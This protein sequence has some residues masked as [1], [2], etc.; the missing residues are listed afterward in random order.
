MSTP[1]KIL[2]KVLEKMAQL[3]NPLKLLKNKKT[4]LPKKYY[5]VLKR[6]SFLLTITMMLMPRPAYSLVG[7]GSM[8]PFLNSYTKDLTGDTESIFSLWPYISIHEY[9]NLTG[10]FFFIPEVGITL[11]NDSYSESEAF[12]GNGDHASSR[13]M[14]FILA[15]FSYMFSSGSHLRFGAGSFM[16]SISGEGGAVTRNDGA[17]TS[18]HYLPSEKVT[19]YNTTI[20]LGLEQFIRP[21]M[22]L[23]FES[24]LWNILSSDSRRVNFS[25][26]F[27]Y[28][29]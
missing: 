6:I 22:A 29:L 14:T 1:M 19:S 7:V 13:Q 5:P 26:A 15:N 20:N 28:Y 18:I 27:N 16:T 11:S 12:N 21:R 25:L 9:F 3:K 8:S 23:K 4:H 24:Y 17:G 10:R 2:M